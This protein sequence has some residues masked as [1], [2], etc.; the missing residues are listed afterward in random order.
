MKKITAVLLAL[1]L[2]SALFSGCSKAESEDQASPEPSV[3]ATPTPET[4]PEET[5]E[6]QFF[7]LESTV[8][9]EA[10]WP[11]AFG[12]SIITDMKDNLVFKEMYKRT[13]VDVKFTVPTQGSESESFNLLMASQEYPDMISSFSQYYNKGLDFAIEDNVIVPL[14]DYLDLMPNIKALRDGNEDIR[15]GTTTDK[16]HFAGIPA[17]KAD[18]NG[19]PQGAWVGGVIRQDWLDKVG[20]D[21]PRT[22]DQMEEVLKAFKDSGFTPHPLWIRSDCFTFGN[23]VNGGFHV[24]N[25]FYQVNGEVKFGPLEPGYRRYLEKL[26]DWYVKGFLNSDFYA[27]S[28]DIFGPIDK[29]ANNEYA[30]FDAIYTWYATYKQA[31]VDPD[32]KLTA[33]RSLVENENDKVHLRMTS[34]IASTGL[35]VGYGSEYVEL[36]CRFWDYLFSEEGIL[37]SNYGVQGETFDY[38]ENREPKWIGPLLS[39]EPGFNLSDAQG[40]YFLFNSAGYILFDR[41]TQVMDA[42]S[43]EFVDI[44]NLDGTDY[45]FPGTATMTADENTEYANVMGDINTLISESIVKFVIGEKSFSEYDAFIQEIR[46]LGIDRAIAARQAA[47]DRYMAR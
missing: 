35:T 6:P 41:E 40:A 46:K 30:V 38:D 13:N 2:I 27:Y 16:G 9:L 45:Y 31:A 14:E 36:V 22:Y 12:L 43:L 3:A 23:I 39:D 34:D 37:L 28:G 18:K 15:K 11:A 44:W 17:V 25:G 8:T 5:E 21:V 47:L 33:I 19:Q 7:P 20:K 4:S 1:L 29:V 10:W 26:H 42:E 32:F 24:S